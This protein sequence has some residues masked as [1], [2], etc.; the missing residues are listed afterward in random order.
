MLLKR[1]ILKGAFIEILIMKKNEEKLY[2]LEV[3]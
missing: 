1:M 2:K 3:C